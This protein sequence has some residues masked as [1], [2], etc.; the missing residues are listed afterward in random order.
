MSA[1]PSL[2]VT[3]GRLHC[4]SL[5]YSRF[6][7][8]LTLPV[9]FVQMVVQFA[10]TGGTANELAKIR[11]ITQVCNH[12]SLCHIV[13]LLHRRLLRSYATSL[14]DVW[15]Q[16]KARPPTFA[17]FTRTVALSERTRRQLMNTIRR[18]FDFAGVP[19]RILVRA[20][21]GRETTRK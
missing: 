4:V 21:K 11:Y 1:F 14:P 2:R 15:V 19:I 10:G 6:I 5:P 12:A 7:A 9:S 18:D 20:S 8:S 3:C 13:T 17:V 16:V